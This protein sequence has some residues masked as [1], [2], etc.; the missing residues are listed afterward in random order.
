MRA[1]W[2]ALHESLARAVRT[3][4]AATQFNEARKRKPALARFEDAVS[5]LAYLNDRGGDLDE[6][7]AIYVAL[8]ET[9]QARREDASLAMSLA[10]LGLWPA[11]DAIFRR[12]LRHFPG[13]S[14]ELVSEIGACFTSQVQRA[15][16]SRI[17]RLA[18]TL[19]RNTERDVSEGRRAAW[20]ED[21]RRT[22]IPPEHELGEP[23]APPEPSELGIP[24][25]LSTEDEIAAIRA[26]LVPIVGDDADLVIGAAIYGESQRELAQ[27]LGITHEAARKRF[28]RALDRIRERF[29]RPR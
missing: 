28:Q 20:A 23:A 17:S 26:L 21:A 10:W 16:L 24:A 5:L 3:L 1:H 9:V 27:Q 4:E 15:N 11:L 13:A 19:A 6:K 7:D 18:A 8:V 12:R 29:R 2:E 25:G 22:D 14:E